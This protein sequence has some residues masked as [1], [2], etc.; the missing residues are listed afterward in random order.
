MLMSRARVNLMASAALW[1][2]ACTSPYPAPPATASGDI[3]D[4]IHGEAIPDPYRWLEAQDDDA[5]RNW[6]DH[7]NVYA[8]QIIGEPELR[9]QLRARLREL[10]DVDR[11]GPTQKGGSFEY[12]TLRRAGQELPVIYRRAAPEEDVLERIEPD[13]DYESVLDPHDMSPDRTTRVDIVSV[14]RD[15]ELLLY[16]IRDGGQD[17]IEIR[18]RDVGESVD[19]PERLPRGLYGSVNFAKDGSGFYYTRRSRTLGPRVLYHRLGTAIEDDVVLF[20]NDYGP[21]SFINISKLDEDA[22]LVYTV[23]HGWSRSELHLGTRSGDDAPKPIAM[24]VDARFYPRIVNGELLVRTNLKAPNN[25]IVAIDPENPSREAW[26][27][28]VPESDD[29][30]QDFT[31][32]D[33]KLYLTYLHNVSARIRA[34]ALDG[35]AA[36]EVAVPDHHR[37]TIREAGP[38]KALLTVESFLQ[39]ETTYLV[40]LETDARKVWRASEVPFDAT[41]LV[42]EQLRY[43]S[44]DGT[45]IPIFLVHAADRSQHSPEPTL[46]YGYGGFNA[47]QTP[48]FDVMAAAWIEQG[49][50]FALANLRG[51]SEFGERW[52]RDG[53][54][55]RKQNVFDDFLA[56]SEWLIASGYTRS[57]LLAIR[58]ASNGGLLVASALTQRPKLFRAVLCGFPDLDMIRFN[59]FTKTNNLPALLEYGD[60][61]IPEQFAFLRRY[62]PY[63]AVA[64]GIRYPAVML[65]SGDRDTRVPPL[66]ARKMTARLQNATSSGLPVILRYHEKAGHAASGGL[67]L[68]QVIE[69]RASELTFLLT[70][71]GVTGFE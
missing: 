60:A 45:E 37:A 5:T 30:L 54:L 25:K 56:A 48:R 18:V 28:V 15:G 70:Q 32:I 40:D 57:D 38:G 27:D 24:D 29:V 46:L 35:T 52:H 68:S 7:Q 42:V 62:S 61:S 43:P 71:L 16:S 2:V 19:L 58:G 66:Q 39:P 65:T 11:I 26:R 53:M 9:D 59:T 14:H 44:K 22:A 1:T 13:E 50:I 55:E 23:Q 31:V 47:A 21:T 51:G 33:E 12:F 69:D 20:G 6:I 41:G 67:P 10:M 17:E 49:G 4:T 8:E 63:Q 3:V 64:D 34:F 36:G